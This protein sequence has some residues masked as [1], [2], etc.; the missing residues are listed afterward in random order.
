[1][2]WDVA[3]RTLGRPDSPAPVAV[4]AAP[5][6]PP[7]A[8]VVAQMPG[9][10]QAGVR[11]TGNQFGTDGPSYIE[12]VARAEARRQIRASAGLTYLNEVVAASDDSMLHRWD[13]RVTRPVR[14]YIAAS[15]AA[16]YQPAFPDAVRSAV[17]VWEE[18]VPIR[19]EFTADSVDAEVE[20]R[21]RVQFD[22]DRTGQTDLI[23][24]ENG[25]IQN[26]VVTLATFDPKGQPMGPQEIRLVALHELGHV[27][28]LDHSPDSA[29]V[30]FPV[31][32]AGQLTRR[33]VETARLLYRL[34]PGSLR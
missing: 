29:D 30:M 16:N 2:L 11:S 9:T 19:F 5:D 33:D 28:G 12:L 13:N 31:A 4:P 17:R 1:V 27:I 6:T 7:V 10:L 24:D 3:R 8:P 23:W 21:W 15:R 22:I 25:H 32:T 20:V 34:A 14:V 26:G 18:V